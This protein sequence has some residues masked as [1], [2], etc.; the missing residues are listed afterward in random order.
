M[1][2]A[3]AVLRT[4][5]A[6]IAGAFAFVMGAAFMTGVNLSNPVDMAFFLGYNG[7]V[8]AGIVVALRQIW[9]DS[10]SDRDP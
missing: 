8:L 7:F 5:A 10:P 9:A 4:I 3:K 1:L 2:K 6:L